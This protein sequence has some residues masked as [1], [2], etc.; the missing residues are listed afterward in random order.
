MKKK[1]NLLIAS[2]ALAAVLVVG[3]A[4][5]AS[6]DTGSARG[7]ADSMM[8]GSA[9]SGNDMSGMMQMMGNKDMQKMMTG[10]NSPEGKEMTKACKAF[11]ESY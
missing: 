1:R 10:M 6:N 4:A 8:D 11:M 7:G 5:F 2:F 3:Q 9:M